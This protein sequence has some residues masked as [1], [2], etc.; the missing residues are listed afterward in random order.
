MSKQVHGGATTTVVDAVSAPIATASVND[1]QLGVSMRSASGRLR[2]LDVQ[3]FAS[4]RIHHVQL[5]R[6]TATKQQTTAPS[7]LA[8]RLQLLWKLNSWFILAVSLLFCIARASAA[9]SRTFSDSAND[10]SRNSGMETNGSGASLFPAHSDW[11][12][13][14]VSIPVMDKV[15][16]LKHLAEELLYRGYRVGFALPENCRQWVSDIE[17]LE[18]ISLGN[19]VGKGRGNYLELD[20]LSKIGIYESY[21]A[22]LRYYA[23]FQRPMFGALLENLED[24]R[25]NLV[26]VDRYTFAGLDACHA[27]QIPYAVNDPHM[28]LDMDTPPAYIPAPFSNVSMHTTSV[29]ERCVNSYYRLRFRLVM[30]QAYKEINQVRREHGLPQIENKD[31]IYGQQLVLVN[32]AFGLDYARPIAPQ[33]QMLGVLRSRKLQDSDAHLPLEYLSWLALDATAKP[34]VFISFQTDIPLSPDFVATLVDGLERVDARL[35][36]KISLQEQSVFDIKSRSRSSLFFISDTVDEAMVLTYSPI[37]VLITAGDYQSIQEALVDGIPVLGIPFSAEQLEGVNSVVRAGAG[38][39]LDAHS[40]TERNVHFAVERLLHERD[41]R[42]CAAYVGELIRAGGGASSAA[43][44]VLSVVEFGASF[45]LPVKNTQPLLKTYLV[46]VYLIYGAILCGAAVILRTFVSILCAIFQAPLP[47]PVTPGTAATS[48]SATAT[49]TAN[50]ASSNG[51]RG[52]M[53]KTA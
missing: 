2:S 15:L 21:A 29:W 3:P 50:G 44:H 32:S 27:L 43:D 51:T 45:L 1:W 6:S 49:A 14:L 24:D 30:V 5:T 8:T 41:F 36:W 28:L 26:V 11:Y 20:E 17:H 10:G 18:F 39:L 38:I 31:Q 53:D 46:D 9:S 40:F 33:F 22:T 35:V 47:S 52:K 7:S 23:S 16:P 13:V 48:A 4:M 42:A 19:I 12:I 34:I 25:P 37:S